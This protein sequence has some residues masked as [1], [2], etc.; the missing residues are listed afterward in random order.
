MAKKLSISSRIL[1]ALVAWVPLS[2]CNGNWS[3]VWGVVSLDGSPLA[4]SETMQVTLLFNPESAAGVPAAA[5]VGADGGYTVSTGSRG[6]L[7][8]GAYVVTVSAMELR[9]L[10]GPD[11]PPDRRLVTPAAYAQPKQSGLRYEISPGRNRIDIDLRSDAKTD[12]NGKR[13]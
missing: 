11:N 5:I 4:A 6:G 12:T 7:A 13:S 10:N 2:G 8:P 3:S 9:F 1:L